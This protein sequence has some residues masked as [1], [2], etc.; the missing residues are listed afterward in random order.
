MKHV[1]FHCSIVICNPSI[2]A[3]D[4][5]FILTTCVRAIKRKLFEDRKEA[6]KKESNTFASAL[7]SFTIVVL[8]ISFRN[9]LRLLRKFQ[10]QVREK[11]NFSFFCANA[12]ISLS[13][14]RFRSCEAVDF[15][16]RTI[17]Q[18]G[19]DNTR[20]SNVYVI[21]L[22]FLFLLGSRR[23]ALPVPRSLVPLSPCFAV[24]VDVSRSPSSLPPRITSCSIVS[25]FLQGPCMRVSI[26][27]K[28]ILRF[29]SIIFF[30]RRTINSEMCCPIL[31]GPVFHHIQFLC[32]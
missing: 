32:P 7:P 13:P 2:S 18:I 28:T 26:S 23:T 6:G 10:F 16:S 12:N 9:S 24:G 14:L 29:I 25:D 30:S 1:N 8:T 21:L 15:P 31:W 19:H 4:E 11:I 27:L 3:K 5:L 22:S 17:V 20:V